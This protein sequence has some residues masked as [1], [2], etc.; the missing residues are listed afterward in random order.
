MNRVGA[1]ASFFFSI[2]FRMVSSFLTQAPFWVFLQRLGVYRIRI[3]EA[4]E[5]QASN[6]DFAQKK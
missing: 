5:Y 3:L 6:V 4:M 2:V 1:H